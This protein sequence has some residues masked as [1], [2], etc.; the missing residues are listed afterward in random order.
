[1]GDSSAKVSVNPALSDTK[2]GSLVGGSVF[3]GL[4]KLLNKGLH[5][6]SKVKPHHIEQAQKGVEFA[7]NAL[8]SLGVGGAVKS[9]KHRRAY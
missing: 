8:K 5:L 1:V 6:A 7:Q 3:G 4:G 9:G 2:A